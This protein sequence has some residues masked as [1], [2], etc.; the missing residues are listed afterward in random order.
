[1]VISLNTCGQ[2]TSPVKKRRGPIFLA[3]YIVFDVELNKSSN[4]VILV[5]KTRQTQSLVAR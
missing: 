3:A 4:Q 2:T 1:M 5:S